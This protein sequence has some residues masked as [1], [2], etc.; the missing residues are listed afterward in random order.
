MNLTDNEILLLAYDLLKYQVFDIEPSGVID[1]ARTIASSCTDAWASTLLVT[2]IEPI[3]EDP[4]AATRRA[5]VRAAAEIGAML[6]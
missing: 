5:I 6:C 4:F 1:F 3:N 2:A